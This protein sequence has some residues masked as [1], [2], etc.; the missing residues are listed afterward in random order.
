[1]HRIDATRFGLAGGLVCAT[2]CFVVTLLGTASGYGADALNMLRDIFWGYDISVVGSLIG[3][4][5]GFIVGFVKLFAIA[6]IYNML[7]PEKEQQ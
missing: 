5:Y 3:A 6:F 1:M 7:G 2:L 4:L